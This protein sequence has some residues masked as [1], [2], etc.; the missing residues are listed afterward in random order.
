MVEKITVGWT[1]L[2]DLPTLTDFPCDS[3]IQALTHGLT[4]IFS[5]LTDSRF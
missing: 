2:A 1:A 5:N 3:R 4:E